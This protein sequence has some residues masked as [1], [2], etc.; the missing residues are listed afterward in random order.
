MATLSEVKG[1]GPATERA[2]VERGYKTAKQLAKA[3]PG[4]VVIVS[5]IGEIR[6]AMLIDAA[7]ALLAVAVAEPAGKK[8]ADSKKKKAK[9]AKAKK[10]KAKKS[11]SKKAKAKKKSKKK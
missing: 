3:K 2:L 8:A 9:A 4:D 11:K 10:D 7:K 6:A 1:V 5:G